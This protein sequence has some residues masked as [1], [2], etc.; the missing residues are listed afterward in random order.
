MGRVSVGD[1]APAP[2]LEA[3]RSRRSRRSFNGEKLDA[4]HLEAL[5]NLSRS[6]K[7]SHTARTVVIANAPADIFSGIVGSYGRVSGAPTALAFVGTI[8]APGV[9]AAVGYTGEA[10]ILEANHLGLSTCWVAGFFKPNKVADL[11]GLGGGER[12]FAISPVGHPL[13][14]LTGKERMIY[15]TKPDAPK[16]RKSAEEIAPGLPA[17]PPWARAGVEAARLAPSAMNRQPWKFRYE[18]GL[19]VVGFEGIEAPK[20]SKALDCGIAMLHFDLGARAAGVAGEW[21]LLADGK[22]VARYRLS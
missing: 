8:G 6:F 19:V 11:I 12:V 4:A 22:D 9:D 14:T 17:W 2:W 5:E 3:A 21:E 13:E 20:V 7:P 10:L 16:P 18:E 15:G 1:R